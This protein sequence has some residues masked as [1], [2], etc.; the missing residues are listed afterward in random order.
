MVIT[1]VAVNCTGNQIMKFPTQLESAQ[2]KIVVEVNKGQAWWCMFGAL[3]LGDTVKHRASALLDS[4]FFPSSKSCSTLALM[5]HRI[6]AHCDQ[7]IQRVMFSP[8]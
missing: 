1:V 5:R 7:E 4:A 3:P 2:A 8:L 6:K